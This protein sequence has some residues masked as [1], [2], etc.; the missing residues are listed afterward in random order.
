MRYGYFYG[1]T[2]TNLFERGANVEEFALIKGVLETAPFPVILLELPKLLF[3]LFELLQA[4][5][6]VRKQLINLRLF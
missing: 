3:F 1:C 6:D 2:C 4:F 5:L